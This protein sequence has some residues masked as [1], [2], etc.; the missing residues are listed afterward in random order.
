MRKMASWYC[1]LAL[2]LVLSG[3]A[4]AAEGDGA[5]GVFEALWG[6]IQEIFTATLEP[7]DIPTSELGELSPP[8]G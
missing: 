4:M 6:A 7:E 3:P 8:G 5:P 1:G 2:C